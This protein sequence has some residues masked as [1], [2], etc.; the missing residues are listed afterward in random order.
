MRVLLSACAC[1][2]YGGSELEIG[3]RWALEVARAGHH[4]W[5][6]TREGHREA[7]ERGLD[8]L[9]PL[10]RLRF[11]YYDPPRWLLGLLAGRLGIR[12]RYWFWQRGAHE[13]ARELCRRVE[14]DRVHHVTWQAIRYPTRM[15]DLGLRC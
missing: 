15:G 2:P 8:A 4:V 3:W 11:A 10:P 14:F 6:L 1:A 7:I 13:V 9:E 12:A 5:V